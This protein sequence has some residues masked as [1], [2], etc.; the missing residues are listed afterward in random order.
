M[1]RSGEPPSNRLRSD[2]SETLLQWAIMGLVI[3]YLPSFLVADAVESGSL[4][5]LLQTLQS[6]EYGIFVVRPPGAHVPGKVPVPIDALVDRFGR[7]PDWDRCLL[8]ASE[9]AIA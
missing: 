7:E 2:S 3:A 9:Q 8:R 4:V 5:P 6:P 1:V